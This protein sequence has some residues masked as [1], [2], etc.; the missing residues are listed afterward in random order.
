VFYYTCT[1]Q[2][3]PES[4]EPRVTP[5]LWVLSMKLATCHPSGTWNLEVAPR[6]LGSLW[7]LAE[8]TGTVQHFNK[9]QVKVS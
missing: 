5:E 3:V 4:T 2:K 8:D 1:K 6:F 7:T 9:D